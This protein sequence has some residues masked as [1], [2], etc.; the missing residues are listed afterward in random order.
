M[1]EDFGDALHFVLYGRA[2]HSSSKYLCKLPMTLILNSEFGKNRY[3][4][5]DGI[6]VSGN[7]Y[8]SIVRIWFNN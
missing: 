4:D 8:H 6:Q 5:L 2:Q 1:Q 7:R 3:N